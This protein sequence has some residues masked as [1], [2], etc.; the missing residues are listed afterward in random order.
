MTSPAAHRQTRYVAAP[1][2]SEPTPLPLPEPTAD[3]DR[4]RADLTE[5]GVCI[6]TGVLDETEVEVLCDR[7]ERQAAAERALGDRSPFPGQP[8]QAAPL[9]HGQQ[10][11]GVPR[12]HRASGNRRTRRLPARQELSAVEHDRGRVSSARRRSRSS[13]IATRD[14]CR[15]RRISRRPATSS[16]CS[17]TSRPSGAAP[18]SSPAVTAGRPSIWSS[19]RRGSRRCRSPPRRAASTPGDGRVWHSAGA[20]PAGHP[21][22]HVTTFF[23]LPWTRQQENWGVTCLQEVLDE[24]SP[25]LRARLGL[26]TYGTLGLMSGTRTSGGSGQ[27]RQL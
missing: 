19:P 1:G 15:R 17:T 23:C 3:I 26:R 25:K 16:G 14:R 10:G 6:L 18:G 21:R 9:E 7:L 20:N 13:C 8:Q 24:A 11:P 4:A 5:Y 27:P 12:P 22:R 2:F